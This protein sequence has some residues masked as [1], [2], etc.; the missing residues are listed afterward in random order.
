[1]TYG[2]GILSAWVWRVKASQVFSS[3]NGSQA[4]KTTEEGKGQT[5]SVT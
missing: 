2:P 3:A 5:G 4:N 1:M